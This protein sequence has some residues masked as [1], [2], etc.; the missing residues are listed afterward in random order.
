M[1]EGTNANEINAKDAEA[2]KVIR[3]LLEKRN[4]LVALRALFSAIEE[5]VAEVPKAGSTRSELCAILKSVEKI[6][7][8]ANSIGKR[9][10]RP[11]QDD[12][13]GLSL[14]E[15]ENGE[16]SETSDWSD[17]PSTE[18]EDKPLTPEGRT[19][20]QATPEELEEL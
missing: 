6:C 7:I 13:A 18:S 1:A 12:P 16:G 11:G 20:F 14:L 9:S 3:W 10:P 17:G 4:E 5:V 19:A 2:A 15:Y 8:T